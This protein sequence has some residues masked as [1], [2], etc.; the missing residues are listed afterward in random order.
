VPLTYS[1]PLVN[2]PID[3]ERCAPDDSMNARSPLPPRRLVSSLLGVLLGASALLSVR[4]VFAEETAPERL[5]REGRALV[6]EGRFA[7]ACSRLEES[8]RLEPRLGTQLNVAFCHERLGKIA[9]AWM[10]FRE[11]LITARASG[12][13]ARQGFATARVDDLAPRVPWLRVRGPA[14]A[15]TD[16]LTILL[17]GV[18]IA[19]SRWD[20]ELPVDPGEH[21]LVAAHGGEEYWRTRVLLGESEH[22]VVA[23][24]AAPAAPTNAAAVTSEPARQPPAP[25]DGASE[26]TRARVAESHADH[27]FVYE[28]GAFLGWMYV[29]TRQSTPDESLASI[30]GVVVD[31]DGTQRLSCAT[32]ICDYHLP[33]SSGFVVGVAGFAGYALAP[34]LS[35]GLRLLIGPRAGGGALVALGPSASLRVG[36][37]F[38]AGPSVFFG[39]ASHADQGFVDMEG[40]TNSNPVDRDATTESR[41]RATLGFA[42]GLGAEL[43]LTL[44][45]SPTGSVVLQAT[46]LFLYGP[47]G[48]ALSLPL[49]VAYRWN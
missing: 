23:I 4:E 5:F 25:R 34:Q 21:A 13:V 41:L 46:P 45:S 27:R 20:E 22:R 49:G 38:S 12:D 16:P 31:E 7:E 29:A 6:V 19:P 1:L 14:G 9:T 30:Q 44:V 33:D 17:D 32:A 18:P 10:G 15:D 42:I 36:D 8:Q 2:D 43:G 37:R 48:T 11:A 28:V 35:L 24:P 26:D 40:P 3:P 39:T 47:N